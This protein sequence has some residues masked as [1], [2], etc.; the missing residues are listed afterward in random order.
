[1]HSWSAGAHTCSEMVTRVQPQARDLLILFLT[2]IARSSVS[3]G[4]PL[5]SN[6]NPPGAPPTVAEV[7]CPPVLLG[8]HRQRAERVTEARLAFGFKIVLSPV[9]GLEGDWRS[10]TL[11]TPGLPPFAVLTR[12]LT[13]EWP[14]RLSGRCAP[15]ASGS[16]CPGR[17]SPPPLT[18]TGAHPALSPQSPVPSS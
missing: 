17:T 8:C 16:Q 12:F 3:H 1:M 5:E 10:V 6:I 15:G 13:S 4:T 9:G 18:R 14:G 11:G 7:N 2:Q